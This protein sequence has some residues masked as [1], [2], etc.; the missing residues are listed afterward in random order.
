MNKGYNSNFQKSYP[1]PAGAPNNYYGG[2]GNVNRQ[3][4]EDSLKSL[5]NSNLEK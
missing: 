3:S 1:N 4:L 2:N 5:F